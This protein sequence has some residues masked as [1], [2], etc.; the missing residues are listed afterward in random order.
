MEEKR[1]KWAKTG[2]IYTYKYNI[3]EKSVKNRI[4]R[5]IYKKLKKIKD[6]IALYYYLNY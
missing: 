4:S 3:Q 5:S 6:K 1:V 2:I